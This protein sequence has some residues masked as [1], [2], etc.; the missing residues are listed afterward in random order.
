LNKSVND[1]RII[2]M[3]DETAAAL[4]LHEFFINL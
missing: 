4:M 2:A 3:K 1:A